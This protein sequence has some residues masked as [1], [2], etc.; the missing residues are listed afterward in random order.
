MKKQDIEEI[1]EA[2]LELWEAVENG[3]VEEQFFKLREKAR[4]ILQTG[5]NRNETAR[6]G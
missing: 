6:P 2:Y 4:G 1:I 3:T 5:G